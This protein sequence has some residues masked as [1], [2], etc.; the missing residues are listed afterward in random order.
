MLEFAILEIWPCM[1]LPL[2]L[3]T[4]SFDV[5]RFLTGVIRVLIHSCGNHFVYIMDK[6][7]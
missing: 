4:D 5:A 1:Y 2:T 3:M 6:I 7:K